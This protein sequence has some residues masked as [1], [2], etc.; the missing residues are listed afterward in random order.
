M[1]VL[2]LPIVLLDRA[3]LPTAVLPVPVVTAANAVLPTPTSPE[4]VSP[5]FPALAPAKKLFVP[6][7]CRSGV[8]FCLITPTVPVPLVV[9][10]FT[11]PA[12]VIVPA[13]KFPLASRFTMVLAVLASV[14]ALASSSARWTLAALEVLTLDTTVA[15]CVP[16]TSPRSEPLKLPAVVALV[17]V[18]AFPVR[19]PLRLRP[20]A[21]W[22]LPM[23]PLAILALVMLP[24]GTLPATTA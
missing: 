21:S 15:P 7:V 9:E 10:R 4:P 19:V 24:S 17:A 12:A 16:V 13:V 8:L 22:L 5:K 11:S 6:K 23:A 20:V 1:A 14:A 18:E 3:A 2:L